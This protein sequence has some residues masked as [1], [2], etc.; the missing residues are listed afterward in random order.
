MCR[1]SV[2]FCLKCNMQII[3][4]VINKCKICKSLEKIRFN[5]AK[6]LKKFSNIYVT[7]EFQDII[8][9]FGLTCWFLSPCLWS[10][11]LCCT[12]FRCLIPF[13]SPGLPFFLYLFCSSFFFIFFC[14]VVIKAIKYNIWT[15]Y[16]RIT[17]IIKK[18]GNEFKNKNNSFTCREGAPWGFQKSI[19]HEF[20]CCQKS[21]ENCKSYPKQICVITPAN[22]RANFL[23]NVCQ[24]YVNN[25]NFFYLVI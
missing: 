18:T 12:L 13:M 7:A 5:K 14:A 24:L 6:S 19:C 1:I 3:Y 21:T 11:L 8:V 20:Y 16:T 25:I 15:T 22:I 17:R 10:V 23:C 4:S 2:E 9:I